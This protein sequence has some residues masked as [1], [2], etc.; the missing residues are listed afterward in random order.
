MDLP[1]FVVFNSLS[2][3]NYL[4]PGGTNGYMKFE[5]MDVV[6]WG[7]KHEVRKA[8]T[9]GGLIHI[10]CCDTGK[11]WTWGLT[12]D[13]VKFITAQADQPGEDTTT[14]ACT[15]I[16][17]SHNTKDGV[18][19]INLEV[20]YVGEW[21]PIGGN[22]GGYLVSG[23][24]D[25]IISN[26][27]L[28]PANQPQEPSIG[29]KNMATECIGATLGSEEMDLP[30]FVSFNSLLN[31]NYLRPDGINNYI[32]F[33]AVDVISWGVKH[34]VQ[35]AKSGGGLVHIRCCDTGKYWSWGMTD[36]SK[37]FITA[38]ANQLG[39]DT[40]TRACTLI[41]P[42]QYT[43]DGVSVVNFQV[44]YEGTWWS[45][46]GDDEGYLVTGGEDFIVSDWEL[47]PPIGKEEMDL[48][49]FVVFNSLSNENYLRPGGINSYMK[50]EVVDVVK[51]GVKHEVQKAKYGGGLVHIR[52]CNTSKYWSWGLTTDSVNFITAQADQ[53]G[54]DT[55]TRA[56]TLIKPSHNTKDGVKVVNLQVMYQ[57]K[58]L[59]VGRNEGGYLVAGDED[60]IVSNWE[61]LPPNQL[62]GLG[63]KNINAGA[64]GASIGSEK[65]AFQ[66]FKEE[67]DL[68]KFEEEVDLPKFVVFNSL[69][70]KNYLRPEGSNSYMKFE[71]VDAISWGVKHEVM[72]K[73]SGG[74]LVHIR[75]CDTGK[76]WSWGLTGYSRSYIVAQANHPAEDTTTRACTLIKPSQYTKDGV[77]VVNLQ[78]MQ[79]GTWWSIGGDGGGYLVTGGED[80]IISDWELL[81]RNQPQGPFVGDKNMYTGGTS[82]STGNEEMDLPK[83]EEE[84]HLTKIVVFNSLLNK[85]YLR[86]VGQNCYMKFDQTAD[87]GSSGVKHEIQ[88]SK[89]GGGLVHIRCCDNGKYWAWGPTKDS[90]DFI[91]AQANQPGEDTSTRACTLIKPSFN[92]K[93]G[94]SAINLEVMYQGTWWPIGG[95]S[96]GYLKVGGEDFIVSDW[97]SLPPKQ[98][99]GASDGDKNMNTGGGVL[100][101][102]TTIGGVSFGSSNNI[103]APVSIGNTIVNYQLLANTNSTGGDKLIGKGGCNCVCKG[104]LPDGKPVVVKVLK[105]SKVS[106]K[107]F[108]QVVDVLIGVCV[109]DNALISVYDLL[110]KGNLEENLHGN[111]KEK[112][113]L[114]WEVRC[115]VAVGI[116]EVLNYLHN[117]CSPPVIHRDVK[118]SNILLLDEFEPKLSDFGLAIWGAS[119]S[120]FLIDN[121]VL[122]G[123]KPISSESTKG[124][125]SLV[126][127]AK[128][129]LESGY[130][131]SILDPNLDGNI[132]EVQIQ[133]MAL[134]VRFCLIR[135][136]WLHPKMRQFGDRR[137]TENKE[138][139]NDEVYPHSSTESHLTLAL[140]DTEDTSTSF[141]SGEPSSGTSSEEYLKGRWSR[142]SSLD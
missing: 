6:R 109:E 119:D 110:P 142:S 126:I 138:N 54:E 116:A 114:S 104:I 21:W 20:M 47:L 137:G 36:Y 50:F 59:S 33:G 111:S 24:E 103:N 64:T 65:M 83:F 86:P 22:K 23:D 96:R 16:K 89:S 31:K 27:E 29:D 128:P 46:G 82:A 95:D 66:K 127:W 124:Q 68:P 32:K 75:C 11:Y 107:D 12:K 5:A 100:I 97:E 88:M 58:W 70:N 94:V 48:P 67:M 8:K 81:P 108:T 38:Q 99:Q 17:P 56:C 131:R 14:R 37:S 133:R 105:S 61:T 40:T 1:K 44:M 112:S 13:S 98:P 77:S 63:D 62:Q 113:V 7:V 39:E 84:M 93:D 90:V 78:V 26:W 74:G 69:L 122:S 9:G 49:K 52:C 18:K 134:A 117:E 136:A 92:T 51:W 60:F 130:L 42:S 72:K 55:T 135:S 87:V 91:T 45:I 30:K 102:D 129:K 15:L 121:D 101:G 76:Y 79:E 120:S 53:P 25:F 3:K 80:F 118:S 71:V 34:E 141:S 139:T 41:K 4:R 2:N 85:N 140:L 106:W 132:D 123:R 43:K 73:K 115:K 10:R 35:K 28:L 125:E 19:V 57:G